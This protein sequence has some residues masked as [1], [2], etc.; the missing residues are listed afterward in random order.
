MKALIVDDDPAARYL[1][2]RVLT[3]DFNYAVVE[4]EDGVEALDLLEQHHFSVML[5][6]VRM[7]VM[8]GI[9]TLQQIR[10][11]S[12]HASLHVVMTTVEKDEAVVRRAVALGITDYLVKTSD[13]KGF[14]GRLTRALK[15]RPNPDERRSKTTSPEDE[16]SLGPDSVVMIVDGDPDF[17]HFF[18]N[19][20]QTKYKVRDAKTAA[21]ALKVCREAVPAIVFLGG[22]LGIMSRECFVQKAREDSRMASTRFVA[23][24]PKHEVASANP[25]GLFDAV[26]ARSFVPDV[27]LRQVNHLFEPQTHLKRFLEAHPSCRLNLI[28]ATE[29]VFGMMIAEEIAVC[30]SAAPDPEEQT[31]VFI[32]IHVK[33]EDTTLTLTIE[34]GRS[35]SRL[36]T[37][38]MIG[39]EI[40]DVPEEEAD[41]GLLEIANVIGGRVQNNLHEQGL[42]TQIGLP[43]PLDLSTEVAAE[44]ADR[45]SLTFAF[46]AGT[47]TFSVSLQVKGA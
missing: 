8:N 40:G 17:R 39:A 33:S 21:Q 11:S 18:L 31:G 46:D 32:P 44:K 26:A 25:S 14:I 37:A 20:F 22:D 30:P 43:A 41:C 12:K 9:E 4:A 27:F 28:T 2:K 10:N 5:L 38:R 13:T 24:A 1:L 15:N 35:T 29:Q 47:P 7:P 42:S 19:Q 6:D 45:V 16:P 3:H 23:I 34:A 36:I